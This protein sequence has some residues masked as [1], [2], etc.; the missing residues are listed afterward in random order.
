MQLR[1]CVR[2][3]RV[4][5]MRWN[6]KNYDID[7]VLAGESV[8]IDQYVG[9]GCK[10][11]VGDVCYVMATVKYGRG[12]VVAKGVVVDGPSPTLGDDPFVL[13]PITKRVGST[14]IKLRLRRFDRNLPENV[15][16][17]LYIK[18]RGC[19]VMQPADANL[20]LSYM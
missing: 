8:V 7:T 6:P 9:D 11:E 16:K 3:G 12:R 17:A 4:V 5:L 13:A 20:F 10:L 18:H 2:P 19:V 14:S 15:Y 1:M